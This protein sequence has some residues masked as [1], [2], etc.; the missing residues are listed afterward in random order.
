MDDAARTDSHI[1]LF[2][3]ITEGYDLKFI[4]VILSVTVAEPTLEV[5]IHLDK[6]Y[7]FYWTWFKALSYHEFLDIPI[8]VFLL[9][10]FLLNSD[11]LVTS[12]LLNILKNNCTHVPYWLLGKVIL[13]LC[14]LLLWLNRII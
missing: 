7:K 4:V 5:R 3:L 8:C 6:S 14:H 1:F 2:I 13:H 10:R 9:R 12:L 11:R